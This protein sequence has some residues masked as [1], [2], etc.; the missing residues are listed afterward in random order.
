MSDWQPIDTV[1]KSGALVWLMWEGRKFIGH[2]EARPP[3]ETE[4]TTAWH[5]YVL[6]TTFDADGKGCASTHHVC[7]QHMLPSHWQPLPE[8][9]K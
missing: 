7:P 6:R 9:L 5:R 3:W 4:D 2:V 1:D 8:P